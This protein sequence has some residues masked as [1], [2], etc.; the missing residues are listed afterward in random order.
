LSTGITSRA[1]R[2]AAAAEQ[3]YQVMLSAQTPARDQHQTVEELLGYRCAAV[4]ALGSEL[5]HTQL[6]AVAGRAGVPTVLVGTGQRN[7]SYDVIR[8][9][10]QHGI[11]R[12]VEHL[13]GRPLGRAGLRPTRLADRGDHCYIAGGRARERGGGTC[14]R[15]DMGAPLGGHGRAIGRPGAPFTS[16]PERH[17]HAIHL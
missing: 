13:A 2:R 10:G 6:K 3:G 17:D 4:L 9:D 11:A 14:E 15:I 7:A 8:S 12:A 5:T 1:S 16:T